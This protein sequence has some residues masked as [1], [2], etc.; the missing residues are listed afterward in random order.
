MADFIFLSL[1]ELGVI[2]FFAVHLKHDVNVVSGYE[3]PLSVVL[4]DSLLYCSTGD[5]DLFIVGLVV[6]SV[7]TSFD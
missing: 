3:E 7:G 2:I 5:D 1:Y 4:G 6:L